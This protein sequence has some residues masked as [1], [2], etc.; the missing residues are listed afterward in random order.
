VANFWQGN[1]A[2]LRAVEP[3]DWEWVFRWELD[4]DFAR[5]GDAVGFPHS[6]EAHRHHA[7]ELAGTLNTFACDRRNG[8]FQYGVAVTRPHW[9]EGYASEAIHPVLRFYFRE[10][11][12]QEATV[13]IYDFNQASLRLHDRFGFQVEGRLRRMGYAEG[14][15]FAW[16]VMGLTHEQF[17]T[18]DRPPASLQEQ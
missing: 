3:E 14:R 5:W 18:L 2:R 6:R 13:H 15:Y 8:A 16:I 11:G 12:Y 4:T 1:L 7:S 17:D 9:R 10:L